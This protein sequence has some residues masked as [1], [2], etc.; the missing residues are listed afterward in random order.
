VLLSPATTADLCLAH[1]Y[2][3]IEYAVAFNF[4]HLDAA[5]SISSKPVPIMDIIA[6]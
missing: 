4:L 5:M 3:L 1:I 6:A 2:T